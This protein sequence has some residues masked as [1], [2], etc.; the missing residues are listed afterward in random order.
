[1]VTTPPDVVL[2]RASSTVFVKAS[3]LVNLDLGAMAAVVRVAGPLGE[4][5]I[6]C[7]ALSVGGLHGAGS[8]CACREEMENSRVRR[9][10]TMRQENGIQ[11]GSNRT[12]N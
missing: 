9:D 1:M 11:N 6:E 12:T 4:L 5:G 2:M 3:S 8:G 7:R 10:L